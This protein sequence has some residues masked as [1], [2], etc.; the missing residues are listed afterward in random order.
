MALLPVGAVNRGDVINFSPEFAYYSTAYMFD[1]LKADGTWIKHTNI[2]PYAP[3]A[4]SLDDSYGDFYLAM[5]TKVSQDK[6]KLV[7]VKNSAIVSDTQ[8][9]DFLTG[10]TNAIGKKVI[11]CLGDS[12]TAPII[13]W[14]YFLEARTGCLCNNYGQSNSRVSIDT[15][16][17][18]SFLTRY[19]SMDTDA[20][21]TIIFGGI[22]DAASIKTHAIELGTI[23]S[24][25]DNTTFYGALKLLIEDIKAL[26]PSKKIIGVIPPDF[27]PND[28]YQ[29]TLPLVQQACRDVYEKYAIPYA[30]LKKECQ[31]MWEES[32]ASGYNNVTYRQAGSNNW[33]PSTLGHEKI[34]EVIQGTLQKYIKC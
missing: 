33:H 5:R 18:Q 27:A 30:D 15:L 11:N 12:F 7:I 24:T 23:D 34:S 32:S 25:L 22:N 6:S 20:D 28:N 9:T 29:N 14:V 16:D 13:S 21:I 8:K 31:E 10:A 19:A 26:M 17:T 4:V 2:N 1:Y 3:M